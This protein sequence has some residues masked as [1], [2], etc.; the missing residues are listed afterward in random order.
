MFCPSTYHVSIIFDNFHICRG[1]SEILEFRLDRRLN[2]QDISWRELTS[3]QDFPFRISILNY[4][5]ARLQVNSKLNPF[6]NLQRFINIT[7]GLE[8][9]ELT[10][11]KFL[12]SSLIPT[13]YFCHHFNFASIEGFKSSNL[14]VQ[15]LTEPISNQHLLII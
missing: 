2:W 7:N 14:L 13:F 11:C 15:T 12:I 1:Q 10:C 3:P 5:T 8:Y 4:S 9:L 6:R